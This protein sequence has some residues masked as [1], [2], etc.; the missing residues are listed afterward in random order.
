MLWLPLAALLN[1]PVMA[2]SAANAAAA[3]PGTT[4]EPGRAIFRLKPAYAALAR[5]DGV[6]LP[7]LQTALRQLGATAVRQKFPRALPPEAKRP[8]MVD[9]RLIYQVE[10]DKALPPAK[11]CHLLRLSGA[12]EYA[13]PRYARQPLYQPNDPLADSTNASGQYHLKNIRAY[14]AWDVTKGDTSML[15]GIVD[16]GTRL[17]HEDLAGQIQRNRRDP[18]DGIDNDNDGYVDNYHGWD[19]ADNDNDPTREANS[20][21]GILVAGCA[22]AAADNGRGIAGVGFRCRFLPLKIYP[23]TPTGSF[24]GYEAIVYAADHGCKVI[25]LSWGGVGGRSRFEQDVITYAAVNRDAV[26]VAAAGNTNAELDFYPASYDHVLSVTALEPNDV[27]GASNTY[28]RRIDLSAPGQQILTALG[29][30]DSDYYPVGGSSFAAPL[31]AGAAALV[32]VR[33]PQFNAEQV[34]AQIRRTTDD[35][36]QL[37]GNAAYAG[38]LGSGRLNVHRAVALTDRRSARVLS[39]TFQPTRAAWQPGDT[40]RL[41]VD[42]QNLLQPVSS[43]T[44]T[45]TSLSPYVTVRQ[46]SFAAGPLATLQRTSNVAA[47]FRLAVA[48]TVPL[49]TRAVLRYRL[50]DAATGYQEDQYE[51]LLLNPDYVVLNA[52]DLLLTLTSRGNLAYDGA[53]S[54]IGEGVSYKGGTPLLYEGGLILASTPTRVSDNVRNDRRGTNMDFST[55]VRT[56]LR[57]QP[58]RATQEAYGTF[59]DSL[60]TATRG[61]SLGLRVRQQAYA[62]ASA[63][64]RDYVILEYHLTNTS[65]DTL[66]S[67]HAGLFMDWD[68]PGEASRNAATWDSV[69]AMGYVYDPVEP[70]LYAGVQ[71]LAG[72]RLSVCSLSNRTQS[73][74]PAYLGDGFTRAEKYMTLSNG[75]HYATLGSATTGTDISQVVGAALPRLAP[76]DSAVVA[77]AV[78][79]APSLPQLQTAAAAAQSQYNLVLPTRKATAGSTAKLYPNPTSGFLRVETPGAATVRVLSPLGQTVLT[80]HTVGAALELN[81]HDFAAGLY[82]VQVLTPAGVST[83]RV[84]LQP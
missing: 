32:R 8:D 4:I 64:H 53:G 22:A 37:P 27:K 13:E 46:G 59:Q 56:V 42:V 26:V 79:A 16:G 62:W 40:L 74:A 66:R 63:P 19:F 35:I 44:V 33:F 45:L 78:L 83:H 49:N 84:I 43:L 82:L 14:R 11:A 3:T 29:N 5:P 34:A 36:Y 67:L 60:P 72:G 1:H 9:L 41:S 18:I 17:T 20:V 38:K 55:L 10:F 25:N 21:H 12:V 30:N 23:S 71:L 6:A 24:G 31:V 58:L 54:D 70:V 76:G 68:L 7:A 52:N 48:G 73:A 77:F 75:T 81:L 61:R 47:P 50:Q 39:R 28:S 65:R 80:H 15:I 2:Q 69:R 57:A 51:T